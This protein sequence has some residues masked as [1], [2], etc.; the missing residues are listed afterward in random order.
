MSSR[1]YVPKKKQYLK[2]TRWLKHASKQ[3]NFNSANLKF[4]YFGLTNKIYTHG[5]RYWRY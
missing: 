1:I 3:V 5:K 2:N 4:P